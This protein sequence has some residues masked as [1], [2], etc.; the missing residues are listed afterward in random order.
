[1]YACYI[2]VYDLHNSAQAM[3]RCK[4]ITRVG[5][6]CSVTNVSTWVDNYGRVVA[7]PLC[8]GAEF[9]ALHAKPFCT[10]PS[11][12][13]DFDRM[14]VFILDLETTGVDIARDRIVE[15]AAVR[16]HGDIRM[17]C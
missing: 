14:I 1:M 12:L 6:Q 3:I 16:A 9:C 2:L 10:S 5:K 13:D 11:M 4:G 15:I 17:N 8:R 7:E